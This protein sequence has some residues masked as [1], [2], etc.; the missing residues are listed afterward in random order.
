MHG[1]LKGLQ[2]KKPAGTIM[3]AFPLMLM[4]VD[5]RALLRFGAGAKVL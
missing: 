1:S 3:R 4:V 5:A 2:G